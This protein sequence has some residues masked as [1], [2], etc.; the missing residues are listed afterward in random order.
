MKKS[1]YRLFYI[2]MFKM[3]NTC[4]HHS[5]TML[6]TV[7]DRQLIIDR[8][9]RLDYGRDTCLVCD[10]NAI[11]EREES[12]GSHHGAIQVEAE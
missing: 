1:L 2:L 10:L 5:Q 6:V 11:G 12:V 4:L 9:S 8:A 3:T 7:L